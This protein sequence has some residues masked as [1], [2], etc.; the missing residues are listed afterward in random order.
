MEWLNY[1]H[2]LYFW[3]A[4]REG[5]ISK[6]ADGKAKLAALMAKMAAAGGA[7]GFEELVVEVYGMP[8]SDA[9]LSKDSLELSFLRWLSTSK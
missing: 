7:A 1:H 6:A 9:D 3:T 2:L 8:Y 4:V 5:S